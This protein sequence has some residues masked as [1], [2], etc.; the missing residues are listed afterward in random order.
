M[1]EKSF[2]EKTEPATP[3]KRSEARKKGQVAKS[4]E[5]SSVAVLVT[6]TIYLFFGAKG[7]TEDMA[8]VIKGAFDMIPGVC[9]GQIG[10]FHV[11]TGFVWAFFGMVLPFMMALSVAAV[12]SNYAQTGFLWTVEPLAPKASKINPI[13][14]VKRLFSKRS[15]V[16]LGKS[17][18]KIGIVGW[19]AFSTVKDALDDLVQ[20]SYQGREQIL[21][22]LGSTAF[23][24]IVRSC[25]VIVVLA[26]LDYMYQKWEYEQNLKMTKQEVKEELK[27]TEGDPLIKGRIRSIQLEKARRRMMEEVKRADVVI[28]NPRHLA[29]A[30]RYDPE[31]MTAPVV[32]GKGA[33]AVAF[34]IRALAGERDIPI[35]ENKL[36]AQNLYRSVDIG[37]EIPSH[38]Y[39]AVAE[40]L[41]YVYSLKKKV[42]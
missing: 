40:I 34:R 7:L 28:T 35:V 16:E 5:I 10:L 23:E 17:L 42:G 30:I 31:T 4:R 14:G 24:V 27:Q 18:A 26:V 2:Q 32:A 36:L 22:L 39:R 37:E 21:G 3:K 38:F 41:A 33:D 12:L 25:C 11:L 6:G 19:A 9:S 13:Q 15:L 20:L 1:A 29:V 8:R